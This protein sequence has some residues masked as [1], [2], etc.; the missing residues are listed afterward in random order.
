M[1]DAE[2]DSGEESHDEDTDWEMDE[3]EWEEQEAYYDGDFDFV[4]QERGIYAREGGAL[5]RAGKRLQ[6]FCCVDQQLDRSLPAG[7]PICL[8]ALEGGQRAWRLPCT[9]VLRE[10]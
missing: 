1:S 7:C 6:P 4:P 5:S 10:A 2:D 3:E 9:H 8:E